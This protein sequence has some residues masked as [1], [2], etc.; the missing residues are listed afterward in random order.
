[1]GL[2]GHPMPKLDGI[3]RLAT[4]MVKADHATRH[5]HEAWKA[6]QVPQGSN[7]P[8]PRIHVCPLLPFLTEGSVLV[9]FPTL[10]LCV[11]C[12]CNTAA[13]PPVPHSMRHC[14]YGKL[15]P[16]SGAHTR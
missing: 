6:L 15:Q 8:H 12:G 16:K 3:C 11:S 4:A 5:V 9:N 1:M 7:C 2:V 10:E 13:Y 14:G